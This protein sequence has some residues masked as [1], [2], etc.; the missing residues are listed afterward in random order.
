MSDLYDDDILAWSQRQAELLRR[1]AAGERVNDQ[2][3]WRNV[4]EEVESVGR[5]ELHRTESL[6]MQALRHRLRIMAWPNSSEVPHWQEEA[7]L[8]QM[9]AARAFQESMRQRL[10]LALICRRARHRFPRQIDGQPPLPLP[11]TCPMMLDELLTEP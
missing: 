11:E 5:S 3:D 4:V 8:F 6:L 1:L 7:T 2:V 9:D 10:D